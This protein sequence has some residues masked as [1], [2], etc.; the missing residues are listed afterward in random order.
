M[1]TVENIILVP[2]YQYLFPGLEEPTEALNRWLLEQ[3]LNCTEHI[4]PFF[5]FSDEKTTVSMYREIMEDVPMKF[6]VPRQVKTCIKTLEKFVQ[7][8]MDL[9]KEWLVHCGKIDRISKMARRGT[10]NN[11]TALLIYCFTALLFYCYIPH[12]RTLRKSDS[13]KK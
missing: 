4:D 1:E 7:K 9:A 2:L 13:L 3:K 6:K 10:V 11:V 12:D 5:S 8:M